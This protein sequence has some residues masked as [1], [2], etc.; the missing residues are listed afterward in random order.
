MTNY[1]TFTLDGFHNRL[2]P[3]WHSDPAYGAKVTECPAG[4]SAGYFTAK[5]KW[6]A[7]R[8]YAAYRVVSIVP[9]RSACRK[10]ARLHGAAGAW[11]ADDSVTMFY[12]DGDKVRTKTFPHARPAA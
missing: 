8:S 3:D 11:H 5:G 7:P 6:I 10:H 9:W 1:V 2:V 12:R 4:V